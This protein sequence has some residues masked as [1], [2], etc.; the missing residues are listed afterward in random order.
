[1]VLKTRKQIEPVLPGLKRGMNIRVELV[2]GVEQ[3]PKY[4]V[5]SRFSWRSISTRQ[6]ISVMDN[7]ATK[8]SLLP[9]KFFFFFCYALSPAIVESGH[10]K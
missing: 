6:H 1:M 7:Q 10:R 9:R 4:R 3:S 5:D 2:T 8:G